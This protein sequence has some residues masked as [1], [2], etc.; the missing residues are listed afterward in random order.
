M[1]CSGGNLDLG[2]G[3]RVGAL[4]PNFFFRPPK[5][6]PFH[7]KGAHDF[8]GEGGEQKM[9]HLEQNSRRGGGAIFHLEQN[10]RLGA[11][12]IFDLEL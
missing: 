9:F 1:V 2:L 11:G 5:N 3:G 6:V 4:E 8:G 7:D 12:A 10:S